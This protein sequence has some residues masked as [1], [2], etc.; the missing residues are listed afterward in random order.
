[1]RSG[2]AAHRLPFLGVG[3]M[4]YIE[5]GPLRG[6]ESL[7]TNASEVDHLV[8]SVTLLQGAV[9]VEIDG[10]GRVQSPTLSPSRPRAGR[11]LGPE[12]PSHNRAMERRPSEGM[13]P[14]DCPVYKPPPSPKLSCS[15]PVKATV[16]RSSL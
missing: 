8:A 6:L 1:V 2:L 9:A 14:P 5:H 10:I 7:I 3:S 15:P 16:V 13:A 12:K 4:I 11:L